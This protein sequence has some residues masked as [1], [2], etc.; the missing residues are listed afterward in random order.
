MNMERWWDNVSWYQSELQ[1]YKD[2]GLVR[3]SSW[4]SQGAPNYMLRFAPWYYYWSLANQDKEM[5]NYWRVYVDSSTNTAS[6]YEHGK[7]LVGSLTVTQ[8]GTG[9]LVKIRDM[10]YYKEVYGSTVNM[11]SVYDK[12]SASNFTWFYNENGAGSSTQYEKGTRLTYSTDYTV[13]KENNSLYL[14]INNPNNQKYNLYVLFYVGGYP[15]VYIPEGRQEYLD[16]MRL[17]LANFSGYTDAVMTND[18]GFPINEGDFHPEVIQEVQSKYGINFN[19][20]NWV[21]YPRAPYDLDLRSNTQYLF[22]K[23]NYQIFSDFADQKRNLTRQ[24]GMIYVPTGSDTSGMVKAMIANEDGFLV[25]TFDGWQHRVARWG[26]SGI[27]TGWSPSTTR[28]SQWEAYMVGSTTTGSQIISWSKSATDELLRWNP[29]SGMIYY[30]QLT[31]TAWN[32]SQDQLDGMKQAAQ[33]MHTQFADV[34]KLPSN[35]ER[36]V[37]GRVYPLSYTYRYGDSIDLNPG[38]IDIYPLYTKDLNWDSIPNG[39]CLVPWESGLISASN[40]NDIAAHNQIQQIISNGSSVGIALDGFTL[41]DIETYYTSGNAPSVYKSIFQAVDWTSTTN[42]N[43]VSD[44]LTFDGMLDPRKLNVSV[45]V[46]SNHWI[47]LQSNST[48]NIIVGSSPNSG[49]YTIG[50]SKNIIGFAPGT[51]PFKPNSDPSFTDAKSATYGDEYLMRFVA[52]C[53]GK[54]GAFRVWDVGKTY[55]YQLNP[56]TYYALFTDRYGIARDVPVVVY[57][58]NSATITDLDTGATI[59]NN[60]NV[61]LNTNSSKIFRIVIS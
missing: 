10:N 59:S 61:H 23:E 42:S 50:S 45:G 27:N 26:Q 57:G 44:Y 35:V 39:G 29:D 37:I 12:Y 60:S 58:V 34:Y 54:V 18:G 15:S 17:F 31:S 38:Q 19:F 8:N 3:I 33:Y 13:F 20:D 49:L 1:K 56:T 55:V 7:N 36:Y 24:Y 48:A 41:R 25:N 30:W 43:F 32:L 28:Q 11:P 16:V 53:L 22:D 46:D 2:A 9:I 51:D 52:Q 40:M 14:K 21:I 4:D 5:V 6:A 47:Q